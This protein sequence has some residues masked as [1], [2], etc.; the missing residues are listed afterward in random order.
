MLTRQKILLKLLHHT[1][2]P[3]SRTRFVKLAFLLRRETCVKDEATFYDFVPYRYGPFSFA[4]YREMDALQRKGYLRWEENRVALLNDML[5]A[6]ARAVEVLPQRVTSAVKGIVRQY[7]GWSQRALLRDIYARYPWF[8]TRS[9]LPELLPAKLPT[10][11][12]ARPA[13]YTMGYQKKSVDAF[14]DILLRTGIATVV[15]V[16]SNPVSRKYGFARRT[17]RDIAVKLGLEYLHYPQV[18]IPRAQRAN[19]HDHASHQRLFD[20]YERYLKANPQLV[21]EIAKIVQAKP[22]VLVCMEKEAH[23]CHRGRLAAAVSR[24]TGMHTVHL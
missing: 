7:A 22:C 3:F 10:A 8:A 9:E 13:V 17:I 11:G 2:H 6:V 20:L 14:F 16:R 15:D 23:L 21:I 19:L 24:M 12:P 4:L 18:G 5:P 1:R